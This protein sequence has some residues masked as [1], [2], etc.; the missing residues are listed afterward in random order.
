MGLRLANV[1]NIQMNVIHIQR[2]LIAISCLTV[3]LTFASPAAAQPFNPTVDLPVGEDYHVEVIGGMWTPVPDITIASDAFGIAGS[4]IDFVKDLGI[5]TQRFGELRLRL[6]PSRKHRLRI[7]YVPIRYSAQSVVERRLV[8]RGI[9]F[10]VGLP[11]TSTIKWDSWRFGYEY[12]IVHRTH[13]YF[14][15]IV[16]AKYTAVEATLTSEFGRE[17]AR[18]RA[19]IPAI[20]GVLRIYPLPVLGITAEVTGFKLPGSADA[21]LQGKYVDVDVHGALNFTEQLG[22]QIGYRS[23]DLSYLFEEDSGTLKLDGVYVAALLRF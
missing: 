8:F 18:A 20:G 15:I 16:E 4:D 21:N 12:D 17:F 7:D 6:R 14:G 9:A 2:A 1:P 19:P 23:L 10:T 22:L 3:L 5:D 11:V 13:G